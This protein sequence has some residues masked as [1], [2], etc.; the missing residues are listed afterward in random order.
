[1]CNQ[2]GAFNTIGPTFTTTMTDIVAVTVYVL[3]HLLLKRLVF[4]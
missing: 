1:M 3:K 2:S 4:V